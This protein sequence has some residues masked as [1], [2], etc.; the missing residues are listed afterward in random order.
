MST[1]KPVGY[2]EDFN[3]VAYSAVNGQKRV[4]KKIEGKF[5]PDSK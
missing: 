4:V 5:K 2:Q 1:G 3:D